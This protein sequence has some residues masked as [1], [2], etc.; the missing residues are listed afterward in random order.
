MREWEKPWKAGD[1]G[2][3]DPCRRAGSRAADAAALGRA[4]MG[5]MPDD[6]ALESAFL[7]V[8]HRGEGAA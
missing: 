7:T 1:G 2:G 5:A 3:H 6:R 8:S 4:K